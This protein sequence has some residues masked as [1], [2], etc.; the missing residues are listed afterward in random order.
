MVV[1]LVGSLAGVRYYQA[2]ALY[3]AFQKQQTAGMMIGCFVEY[4]YFTCI[5][6]WYITERAF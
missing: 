5:R 1:C 2:L 4:E 6:S 3:V